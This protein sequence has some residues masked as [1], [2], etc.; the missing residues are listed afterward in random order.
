MY[1]NFAHAGFSEI[2]SLQGKQQAAR[3]RQLADLFDKGG[4]VLFY[5]YAFPHVW[6]RLRP[7][8]V[9]QTVAS[10]VHDKWR[11]MGVPMKTTW[12]TYGGRVKKLLGDGNV[13]GLESLEL[14]STDPDVFEL[15]RQM[16]EVLG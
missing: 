6:R 10:V 2:R 3:L 5:Y 4:K 8:E 9:D 11:L 1:G 12:Q 14:D 7:P 16:K 13:D 15:H